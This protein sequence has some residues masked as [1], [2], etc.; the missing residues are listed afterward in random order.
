MTQTVVI[1]QNDCFVSEVL[2][3]L[4]VVCTNGRA[5]STVSTLYFVIIF[6]FYLIK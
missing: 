3:C 5:R 2:F 4:N 1:D 6:G